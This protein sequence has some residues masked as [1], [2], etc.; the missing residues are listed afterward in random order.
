MAGTIRGWFEDRQPQE[1]H[2]SVVFDDVQTPGAKEIAVLL[3]EP[4]DR[5]RALLGADVKTQLAKNW[6]DQILPAAR[7]IEKGYPFEESQTDTDL[8]KLTDFLAP[9]KGKFSEF[10]DKKLSSYFEEVSGQLKQKE[11]AEI[12]FSDEFVTYLNNAMEPSQG[13]VWIEPDGRSLNT[14]SLSNRRQAR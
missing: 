4:L 13:F 11:N 14:H 6:T 10:Y 5:M 9:E 1:R 7:D 12:K 3:Q 8:A 2:G